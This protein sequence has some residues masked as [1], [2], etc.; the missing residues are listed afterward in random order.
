MVSSKQDDTR[1]GQDEEPIHSGQIVLKLDKVMAECHM[2]LKELAA[3]VG[4]TPVNMSKIKNNRV[5]AIRF[6]TLSGICRELRCQPGDILEYQIAEKR[7]Q[8][9]K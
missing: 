9:V 1:S 7:Q 8:S 6:S 2:S 3:R 5:A 4:I